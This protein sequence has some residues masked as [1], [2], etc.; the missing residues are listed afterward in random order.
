MLKLE[1]ILARGIADVFFRKRGTGKSRLKSYKGSVEAK[2]LNTD[3]FGDA[4]Y[5]VLSLSTISSGPKYSVI[6]VVSLK[7]YSSSFFGS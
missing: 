5:T 7:R 1:F 4:T 6:L 3:F 2:L